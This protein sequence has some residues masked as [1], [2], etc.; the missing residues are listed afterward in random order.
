MHPLIDGFYK[1]R[2]IIKKRAVNAFF[3]NT[4]KPKAACY[5][6]AAYY[7]LHGKTTENPVVQELVEEGYDVLRRWAEP[8]CDC[9]LD[10]C[11][12]IAGIIVHLN[13][14]HE[15]RSFPDQKITDWLTIAV[16]NNYPTQEALNNALA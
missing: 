6:G 7:G 12:T 11:G 15:G 5:I 2:A 4:K 9:D 13:D 3:D 1:G 14:A 8:P 10:N 16:Q